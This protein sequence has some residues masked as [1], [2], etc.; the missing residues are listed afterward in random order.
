M[1]FYFFLQ[2]LS[3]MNIIEIY[4]GK[5]STECRFKDM[6]MSMVC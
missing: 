4:V 6:S 3:L 5:E 2:I 1:S